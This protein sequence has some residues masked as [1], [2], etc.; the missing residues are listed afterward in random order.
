MGFRAPGKVA[1]FESPLVLRK[2][3]KAPVPGLFASPLLRSVVDMADPDT[4][5]LRLDFNFGTSFI[6]PGGEPMR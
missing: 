5:K 4:S 1:E 6:P 3:A 2:E